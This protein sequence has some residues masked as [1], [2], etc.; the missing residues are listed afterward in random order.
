LISLSRSSPS[1]GPLKYLLANTPPLSAWIQISREPKL[2]AAIT[3]PAGVFSRY[4]IFCGSRTA[5]LQ[6]AQINF[7]LLGLTH[8]RSFDV[9]GSRYAI[10]DRMNYEIYFAL[11]HHIYRIRYPS[12]ERLTLTLCSV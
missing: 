3:A 2:R 5:S 1:L 8:S 11:S 12:G 7:P 6:I 9:I 10:L 4:L